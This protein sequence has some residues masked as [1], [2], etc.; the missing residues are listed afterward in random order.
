MRVIV[1]TLHS[2]SH[3]YQRVRL[4]LLSARQYPA[5]AIVRDA[6]T[7]R[8]YTNTYSWLIKLIVNF[9]KTILRLKISHE[10][11]HQPHNTFL[12]TSYVDRRPKQVVVITFFLFFN[13]QYEDIERLLVMYTNVFISTYL[14]FG[15]RVARKCYNELSKINE[16]SVRMY[17]A[18]CG[19]R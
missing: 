12:S 7:S 11:L 4:R 13:M 9:N 14:T 18:L 19:Y 8:H 3:H 1:D 2:V 6:L 10:I 15:R 17:V 16:V 5:S